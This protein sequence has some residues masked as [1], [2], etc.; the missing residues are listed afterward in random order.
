MKKLIFLAACCLLLHT[1]FSQ[2]TNTFTFKVS[3]P[4]CVFNF[5]ESAIYHHTTSSTLQG[6]I[7]EKSKGSKEF[8][9]LCNDFA[10]I[11]LDYIYM[12][13]EF[14]ANR[15][16]ARST[17]DLV[18][19]ALVNSNTISEF[20]QRIIGVLPNDEMQKLLDILTKAEVY[21]DEYIWNENE[22]KITAQ[23]KA[24]EAYTAQCSEAFQKIK[25]FYHSSWSENIP[26]VVALYPVPG[27]EG[28]TSA[29][30]HANSLCIGVLSDET[31]HIGRL[32]VVLHEM[33]HVLYD[34]QPAAFQQTLDQYFEENQSPYKTF[35][36]NFF[37][38]GLATALG[39]GWGFKKLSGKID[40]SDWYN[41]EYINGFG[42]A[43]FPLVEEYIAAGKS[44]DK[45]FV[46]RAIDLFAATFPKSLTDYAILFNRVSVFYDAESTAEISG[47][48][49]QI[50]K[51]FQLTNSRMSAPILDPYSIEI[52]KNEATTQLIIVDKNHAATMKE[53]KK[54][55]P[56]LA[57]VKPVNNQ[58]LSFF[59]AKK[60]LITILYAADKNAM[61]P[62][63]KEMKTQKY[64]DQTKI[65]Q[66]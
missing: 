56:Q 22:L 1:A 49:D 54:I 9:Q 14:P 66:N 12:R 2:N 10:A 39:N 11:R 8:A 62:L 16:Q 41:N 51:Y 47:I 60:R 44:L 63:L 29:T 20:G 4:Y 50:G 42:K 28:S 6:Y 32:G 5:L 24:L 53:L 57:K 65:V 18:D 46:D 13:E 45:A 40:E 64:V 25:A 3:K 38:E 27:R 15:R 19:I 55:F 35:A 43:L 58:V 48:R 33:C 59:D 52:L 30:P 31:D 26:F 7:D 61:A 21:Y 23:L 37:D 34:E 17:Y 36:Y